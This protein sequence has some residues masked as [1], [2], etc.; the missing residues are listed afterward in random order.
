MK[1]LKENLESYYLILL[2]RVDNNKI[3]KKLPIEDEEQAWIAYEDM[4][5]EAQEE[6]NYLETLLELSLTL[7]GATEEELAVKYF[8]VDE[9]IDITEKVSLT[10]DILNKKLNLS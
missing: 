8:D 2:V 4:F 1:L 6:A 3:I 10:E 7:M 9:E 5:K